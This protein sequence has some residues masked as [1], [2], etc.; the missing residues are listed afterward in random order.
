MR[1]IL[2]K[3]LDP[4]FNLALDEYAMKHIDV[5]EDFFFLWQNAPSVII[6]KNQNTAEEINQKFIDQNGIKVARRVSGGG[7]VYHDLGNLNFTFVISVD[8]PGKVN[9]KKYVQPIIDALESM[10]IK[11]EASGRNDILVDGLKI[12]GNAQRMANGKLMHHGTIMFDLN[13]E[14]MVKALNV[15]PDKITSKGVKSVRSRVTNIKEHLTHGDIH[16]FWDNLHYYLSNE[17]QDQEIVLTEDDIAK[18]Q[19]EADSKFSTWDWIYGASPEFNLKNS[20]RFSG[21]RLETLMNVVEGKIASIRFVGDYLGL[22]DVSEVENQLMGVR[23]DR[24]DVDGILSQIDLKKYF[25]LIDKGEI[26]SLMFD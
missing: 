12:S 13:I 22:E 20:K 2:N 16:E 26:L 10:G 15:D 25:G 7:A 17:G 11:A 6:G 8:D 1:Y 24:S 4:Y 5:D 9:Y 21:G 23:F 3:S 14:N 19:A 18:I